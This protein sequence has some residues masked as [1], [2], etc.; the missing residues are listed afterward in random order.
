V[1]IDP[2]CDIE[3]RNDGRAYIGWFRFYQ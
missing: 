1:A 3:Q 2:E